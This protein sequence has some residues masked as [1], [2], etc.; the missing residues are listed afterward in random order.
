MKKVLWII[1][2]GLIF[3]S[4]EKNEEKPEEVKGQQNLYSWNQEMKAA[5]TYKDD[6]MEVARNVCQ[7]F[8]SKKV[9]VTRVGG[10]VNLDFN[11][12]N[13]ACGT[14]QTSTSQVQATLS[15]RRSG[16]LVLEPETRNSQLLTDVLSET[17]PKL[18]SICSQ[19]LSG[20]KPSNTFGTGVINYQ[21]NFFQATGY[22]WVQI[23]EFEKRG[24]KFYPYAIERSAVS[25]EYGPHGSQT[26]GFVKIRTLNRPCS[27][28]TTTYVT[29][30]AVF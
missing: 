5:V 29:Q 9:F 23:A 26:T 22:E 19:V 20:I 25:T 13:L 18:Q 30:E 3:S 27:N 8:Q 14:R 28:N 10:V 24:D 6:E 1:L 2:T 7:A 21:V 11:V 15:D 4:C 16:G 12:T 17:H